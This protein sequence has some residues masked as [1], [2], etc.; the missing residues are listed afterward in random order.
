MGGEAERRTDRHQVTQN[1]CDKLWDSSTLKRYN[2]GSE[3]RQPVVHWLCDSGQ[4]CCLNCQIRIITLSGGFNILADDPPGSEILGY[5]NYGVHP[6][7]RE[8]KV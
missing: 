2:E 7:E 5:I 4:A 1:E 3:V 8:F 6:R